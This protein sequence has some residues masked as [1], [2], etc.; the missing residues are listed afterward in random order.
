MSAQIDELEEELLNA[1]G[2][3]DSLQFD[4]NDANKLLE[5]NYDLV[6]TAIEALKLLSEVALCDVEE[7]I[8]VIVDTLKGVV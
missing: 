7:C 2:V 3:I 1:Q 6:Y 5:R 4:L 8:D